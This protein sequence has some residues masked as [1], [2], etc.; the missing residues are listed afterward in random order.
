M[1]DTTPPTLSEYLSE[2]PDAPDSPNDEWASRALRELGELTKKVEANNTIAAK[3]IARVQQWND[4]VNA[5]LES[6]AAF[7]W[8]KLEQYALEQRAD[9]RKTI[10]LPG[11]KLSTR[12]AQASWKFSSEFITWAIDNAPDMLRKSWTVD[13]NAAKAVLDKDSEGNIFNVETGEP[14]PGV[15]LDDSE[16]YDVTIKPAAE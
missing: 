8:Q 13:R 15:E 2:G 12:P 7:L 5:S 16:R 11:G 9:D 4:D 6:R 1:A 14:V 10:S 3:E